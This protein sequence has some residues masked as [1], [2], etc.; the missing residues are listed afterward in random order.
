MK[1]VFT[2]RSCL[3]LLK[4]RKSR[5]L[6]IVFDLGRTGAQRNPVSLAFLRC[7]GSLEVLP[8]VTQFCLTVA[9]QYVD[10]RAKPWHALWTPKVEDFKWPEEAFQAPDLTRSQIALRLSRRERDLNK[11][12]LTRNSPWSMRRSNSFK[13][14]TASHDR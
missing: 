10:I 11:C 13:T 1:F 4:G 7:P 8:S 2:F 3:V 5:I 12:A 6:Q 9:I 14:S